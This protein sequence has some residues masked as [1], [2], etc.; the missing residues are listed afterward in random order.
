MT[1]SE[2]LDAVEEL[3]I[4]AGL[5]IPVR[6]SN[7]PEG[8][9]TVAGELEAMPEDG[10]GSW[11]TIG[12]PNLSSRQLTSGRAEALRG[13]ERPAP[14]VYIRYFC[15]IGTGA[16]AAVAA[17][18]TIA[19]VLEGQA[20]ADSLGGVQF[21]EGVSVRQLGN[22]LDAPDSEQLYFQ[23]EGVLYGIYLTRK[24]IA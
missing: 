17:V 4:N 21:E 9:W 13:N 19:A 24:A 3:V 5:D 11:A 22:G 7:A 1:A 10:S 12:M 6:T 15:P 20:V 18:E 16:P 2:V 23:V 14:L 8:Y